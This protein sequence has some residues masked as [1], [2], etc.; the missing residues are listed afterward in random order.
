M[1][2]IP[3]VTL[4]GLNFSL[5]CRVNNITANINIQKPSGNVVS[6]FPKNEHFNASCVDPAYIINEE[7]KTVSLTKEASNADHGEWKCT[8]TT[9]PPESASNSITIYSKK[10][11]LLNN[12][13]LKQ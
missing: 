1:L 4:N 2:I 8:H 5:E 6:C 13:M 3:E 9:S 7:A 11:V 10:N 12:L